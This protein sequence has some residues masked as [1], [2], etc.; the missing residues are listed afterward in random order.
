MCPCRACARDPSDVIS[1]RLKD[2]FDVFSQHF[3]GSGAENRG[4]GKGTCTHRLRNK[5]YT[6]SSRLY[7]SKRCSCR[8]GSEVLPPGGGALLP[9]PGVHHWEREDDTGR[10][11][12]VGEYLVSSLKPA[13][14]RCLSEVLV[15]RFRSSCVFVCLSV[16]WSRTSSIAR[17]S[18]AAWRSSSSPTDLQEIS[19]TW[20]A[21][22][23]FQLITSIRYQY[24]WSVLSECE[25]VNVSACM[26]VCIL[27]ITYWTSGQRM[28][29]IIQ[30]LRLILFSISNLLHPWV[31]CRQELLTARRTHWMN[32]NIILP[33]YVSQ[34]IMGSTEMR[35]EN[36]N[37]VWKLR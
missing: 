25:S 37:L 6:C 13:A 29:L 19:P 31:H 35:T 14:D 3:E 7:L 2:M 9:D 34:S 10:R 23:S 17:C 11:R 18:S 16:S 33:V 15:Y 26:C 30:N 8:N 22:S 21:S 27:S 12:P 36:R 32:P 24:N 1:R 20:S 28:I 5:T 4:M